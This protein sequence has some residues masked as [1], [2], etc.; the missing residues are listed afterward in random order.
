MAAEQDVERGLIEQMNRGFASIAGWCFDHRWIVS[1]LCI[2][3]LAGGGY[4]ASGI[5]VD[6]SY[7]A[8]FHEGDRTFQAY[9][10]YREDFG[11]D[12][13]AYIGFE[14]PG[15]EYGPFNLEAVR[16][17]IQ[18][19]KALQD[20]VPFVYDVTSLA[21]AEL[22]VG[23]ED[24]IEVTRLIDGMPET[25]QELLVLREAYLRKPMLIGGIINEEADFGGI[26]VEMDL[27]S[28]D[29]PDVIRW[30]PE[31]GDDL[32]NLYPQV[33]ESKIVEILGR[34]EYA[35]FE[36]FV[37][38]DVP[39]NAYYNRIIMTEPV[40]QMLITLALISLILLIGVT[41][42]LGVVVKAPLS[43]TTTRVSPS[44]TAA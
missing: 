31:K 19:T 28:T 18:L 2:G 26:I 25:Q 36:F 12:E 42:T 5:G 13:V 30:D 24:G 11:S 32:E 29:P 33:S 43:L 40:R 14:L 38:G 1:L 23:S 8:Y 39:M 7:E 9:Q 37:S 10:E 4:L 20:E 21:N 34:P 35:D 27:S 6:S 41:E 17:L 44:A 16:K 22:T 3:L 15:L